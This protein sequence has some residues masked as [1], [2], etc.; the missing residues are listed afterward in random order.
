M[1]GFVA[2]VAKTLHYSVGHGIGSLSLRQGAH[3]R[4]CSLSLRLKQELQRDTDADDFS[5]AVRLVDQEKAKM[6][7][8]TKT[9]QMRKFEALL[10]SK[11]GRRGVDEGLD[12]RKVVRNLSE[13]SLTESETNV[14][15]LGLNFAV[16]PKAV[17][18]VDIIAAVE[19]TAN[20]LP[21]ET[22]LEFRVEV[23]KCLQNAKKP[24]SN[25]SKEQRE[26]LKKLKEDESIV[27]LPADKG[28]AT[29]IMNK[30]D[31]EKKMEDILDGSDY[32]V[33]KANPTPKLEK[34]LNGLLRELW[35][36]EEINKT[37]Y[38]RLRATYSATPQL[39]GLPK[40]HKPE[41]PLRPIVSSIDSP[42][43]NLA[44]FLTRI[45][46]PLAA[47]RLRSSRTLET[48]WRRLRS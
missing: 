35:E 2:H 11:N 29:V 38:D 4:G 20:E 33:V 19:C 6:F 22:A 40:I 32:A 24:R 27:I 13:R 21:E 3:A 47:R 26:A 31:Y 28:N 44:K 17:P 15:A 43:Y 1:T 12:K 34:K 16:A 14:L 42:T 10:N 18:V 23:K 46:S 30:E 8:E 36:K 9:R 45:V 5:Y 48:L 39:Y 7:N 41:V 25:L 37:G